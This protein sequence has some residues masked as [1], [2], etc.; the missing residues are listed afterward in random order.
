MSKAVKP[1]FLSEKRMI[2][3]CQCCPHIPPCNHI[4]HPAR[5]HSWGGSLPPPALSGTI[6]FFVS[7]VNTSTR[8]L[9]MAPLGELLSTKTDFFSF[10][11][12]PGQR[13][14]CQR[15]WP[16]WWRAPLGLCHQATHKSCSQQWGLVILSK[17]LSW[18]Y[19]SCQWKGK[20]AEGKQ[21]FTLWQHV[22]STT[23]SFNWELENVK[24][25][26]SKVIQMR[27]E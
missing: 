18:A 11:Q 7:W 16:P 3:V 5:I 23:L 10:W 8:A 4:S 2:E 9:C 26:W 1:T 21:N 15:V 20:L 6:P 12:Q 19:Q 27:R 17:V 22:S 14:C 13:S 24:W 25:L